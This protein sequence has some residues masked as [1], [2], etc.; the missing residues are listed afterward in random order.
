MTVFPASETRKIRQLA[1]VFPIFS[2]VGLLKELDGCVPF[3]VV[4]VHV[5]SVSFSSFTLT[6]VFLFLV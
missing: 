5:R 2:A 3:M 6:N 1:K 4:C